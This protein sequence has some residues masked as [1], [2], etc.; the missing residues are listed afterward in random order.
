M[1]PVMATPMA[2]PLVITVPPGVAPGSVM[3]VNTPSGQMQVTVPAG[4]TEGAQFQI[5]VAAPASGSPDDALAL[6]AGTPGFKINGM[7]ASEHDMSND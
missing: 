2:T 4:V 7:R 3:M 6:F 5:L 1:V